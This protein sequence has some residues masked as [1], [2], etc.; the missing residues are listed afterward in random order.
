MLWV[1]LKVSLLSVLALLTVPKLPEIF[2]LKSVWWT[3]KFCGDI[4]VYV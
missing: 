3:T 4:L 1:V 2:R